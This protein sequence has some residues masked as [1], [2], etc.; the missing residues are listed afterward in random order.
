MSQQDFDEN[1]VQNG[2]KWPFFDLVTHHVLA[3]AGVLTPA[4][5]RTRDL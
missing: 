1:F 5:S 2:A 3:A 4:F